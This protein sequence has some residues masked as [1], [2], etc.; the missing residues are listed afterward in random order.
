MIIK[1]D[2]KMLGKIISDLSAL[3]GVNITVLDTKLS[4]MVSHKASL[5]F[6]SQL[7]DNVPEAYELCKACDK[8]IIDRCKNS[9]RLEMHR[10]HAGL[11][12]FA[13][14]I[15]KDGIV[16]G[17][18]LMGGVR[19]ELSLDGSSYV[20]ERS[21]ELYASLPYL[22][23]A[24]IDALASL[25][26]NILFG[27]AIRT[28]AEGIATQIS[29]YVESHLSEDLSVDFLCRNFC[30]SKNRL[31]SIF[32]E[33]FQETVNEYV[34][35]RRIL[36]AKKLLS[37]SEMPIYQIAESVGVENYTYFC[38]LF[39]KMAGVSAGE[40]RRDAVEKQF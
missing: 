3:T 5:G 30:I 20:F 36:R 31:Y 29:E 6:C 18:I 16:V 27:S 39:K 24:Q 21:E 22:S 13:M 15:S 37:E 28:E 32:E 40:Y 25:M 33:E 19:S 23:A 4:S 7:Q 34:R 35:R 26:P 14:P 17:Y 9:G 2:K 11:Y 1:Y 8:S 38:R 12:D 10:C